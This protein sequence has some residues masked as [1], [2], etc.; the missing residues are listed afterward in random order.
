MTINAGTAVARPEVL[1]QPPSGKAEFGL[2]ELWSYRELLYFLTKRELQIRYKQSLL[3]IGWAV[4]QPLVLT[5]IFALFFGRLAKVPSDGLPYPVFALAGLV[6]WIFVSQATSQSALSLV[7]DANLLSKVYFPRLVIPMAKVIALTAD[8]GI[9]LVVLICFALAYGASPGVE[10]VAVPL[11]IAL[12]F[13]C[14]LGVGTGLSALNV[15]YR[16]VMVAIPLGIQ[17]WLFATPVVYPGSL[18][19]GTWRYVYALNPMVAVIDGV[20]WALLG[21]PRPASGPLLVSVAVV[22]VLLLASV[23]YFRRTERFFADLI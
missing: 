10:L 1:I 7:G 21:T 8:L 15:K 12:A 11:F 3:G 13:L 17:V 5:F 19:E 9:S 4:L 22:C 20:R 6:P 16:D 14:A 2:G 18:I 23:V